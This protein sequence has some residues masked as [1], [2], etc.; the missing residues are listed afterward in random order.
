MVD[1]K[2]HSFK[3]F[4]PNKVFLLI[5]LFWCYT[6]LCSASGIGNVP[7]IYYIS[8]MPPKPMSIRTEVQPTLPIDGENARKEIAPMPSRPMHVRTGVQPILPTDG[9]NALEEIAPIPSRPMSIRTEVEP[10]LPTDGENALEEISPIP[11]RPMNI[12]TEVQPTLPIDG[13]NALGEISPMPYVQHG[14]VHELEHA[15][16]HEVEH[17]EVHEL[18][19]AEVQEICAHVPAP[20]QVPPIALSPP[21]PPPETQVDSNYANST[22]QKPTA[23]MNCLIEDFDIISIAVSNRLSNLFEK[24][25]E[26]EMLDRKKFWR[27]FLK[28]KTKQKGLSNITIF[29][30]KQQGYINGF[31]TKLNEKVTLGLALFKGISHT[32]FYDQTKTIQN[33]QINSLILY[34]SLTLTDKVMVNSN[35]QYGEL[36]L[37][38]TIDYQPSIKTRSRGKIF[39]AGIES[40]NMLRLGNDVIIK[41]SFRTTY[42]HFDIYKFYKKNK[43]I[44]VFIPGRRAQFLSNSSKFSFKKFL[45]YQGIIIKPIFYVKIENLVNRKYLSNS[46]VITQDN[47]GCIENQYLLRKNPKFKLGVSLS[48]VQEKVMHFK[49]QASYGVGRTVENKS[50]TTSFLYN[51]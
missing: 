36:L 39:K 15:E 14:L 16:V 23:V 30:N 2:V 47:Y 38:H 12:R 9:E 49:I 4:K 29:S 41:A 25:A 6:N 21:Q 11:S 18:E 34:N 31:D 42:S 13:E 19:H 26:I 28:G 27:R 44:E 51:L 22:I 48:I 45:T 50:F 3:T 35:V 17:A 37:Q 32:N 10:I 43:E 7:Y 8:P 40:A 33:S 20:V 46:I 1:F 5:I 24:K